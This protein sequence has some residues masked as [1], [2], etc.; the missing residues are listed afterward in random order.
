ELQAK[1]ECNCGK[2]EAHLQEI[3]DHSHGSVGHREWFDVEPEIA[4]QVVQRWRKFILQ[5][6]YEN[7]FGNLKVEFEERTKRLGLPPKP[8]DHRTRDRR[9]QILL[10]AWYARYV[11]QGFAVTSVLWICCLFPLRFPVI[12]VAIVCLFYCDE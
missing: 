6:P 10:Q 3:L 5:G 9:L 4:L 8:S 12:A 2:V 7:V 11:W 1:F